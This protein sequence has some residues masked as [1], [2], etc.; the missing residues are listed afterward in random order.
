MASQ[1]P[2]VVIEE[3]KNIPT[4]SPHLMPF[5]ISYS[6][7]APIQ[8][9]FRVKPAPPP[10]YGSSMSESKA[11]PVTKPASPPPEPDAAD[12]QRTIDMSS[13]T[14]SVS[15]QDLGWTSSS[16]TLV[17]GEKPITDTETS[18]SP[19]SIHFTASFRGRALRG[20]HVDLPEGYSGLVLRPPEGGDAHTGVF[21][22]SGKPYIPDNDDANTNDDEVVE[23]DDEP[24]RF[25][26]PSS[27][28]SSMTLWNPDIPLDE[29]RDEYLRSLTEWTKLA[30]VVQ[31]PMLPIIAKKTHHPSFSCRY[32]NMTSDLVC[33]GLIIFASKRTL[34]SAGFSDRN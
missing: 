21:P 2:A 29:G 23:E 3:V 14:A 27:S 22:K 19:N 10:T 13:S 26:Q 6:G 1:A 17:E 12:S 28:F 7:S 11:T 20:L 30:A 5:H 15:N 32:M 4:C 9:Y 33:F 34:Q 18:H 8:T 31:I 25:L 24:I 16:T